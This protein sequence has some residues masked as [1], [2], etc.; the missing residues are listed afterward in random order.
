MWCLVLVDPLVVEDR[1]LLAA[2]LL[3][4]MMLL[5]LWWWLGGVWWWLELL[6]YIAV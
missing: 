3:V 4:L 6:P 5:G 2:D 1:E